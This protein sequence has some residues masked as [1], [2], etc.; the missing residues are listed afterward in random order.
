MIDAVVGF[1]WENGVSR[2]YE[3]VGIRG[4]IFPADLASINFASRRRCPDENPLTVEGKRS[5]HFPRAF[6]RFQPASRSPRFS[7]ESLHNAVDDK[8]LPR[9]RI[10]IRAWPCARV[11]RT[12]RI[13]PRTGMGSGLEGYNQNAKLSGFQLHG[14]SEY[15]RRSEYRAPADSQ[16]NC[17]FP[18]GEG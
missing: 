6:L 5:L 15:P 7:A 17:R 2:R 14:I 1:H 9:L 10:E 4:G 16:K 18:S 8:I 13:L 3:C 11:P 12:Q